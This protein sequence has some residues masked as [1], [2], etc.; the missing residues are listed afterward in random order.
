M[1]GAT[2]AAMRA[3]VAWL[4]VK[5]TPSTRCRVNAVPTAPAPIR[6]CSASAGTPLACSSRV[7]CRPLSV[8]CSEGLYSTVLPVSS[9]GRITLQPT[10]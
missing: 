10:K 2:S 6:H 8:A 4:P 3:P 5:N 7:M 9:A 1:R